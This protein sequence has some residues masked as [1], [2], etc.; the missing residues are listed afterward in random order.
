MAPQTP[1][2]GESGTESS[3]MTGTSS[4][5]PPAE[6]Q[7]QR[8]HHVAQH[9]AENAAIKIMTLDA[10]LH[11]IHRTGRSENTKQ[12]MSRCQYSQIELDCSQVLVYP[13]PGVYRE[14]SDQFI[15]ARDRKPPWS[16]KAVVSTVCE[17]EHHDIGSSGIIADK[18][19]DQN[20]RE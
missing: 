10:Q 3:R 9:D 18:V 8:R 12:H 7:L 5:M 4:N 13:A 11:I 17:I 1:Q 20:P 6:T 16:S 15:P 14:L 19:I 2:Q